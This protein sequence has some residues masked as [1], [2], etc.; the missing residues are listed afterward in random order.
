MTVLGRKTSLGKT[1]FEHVAR[2]L[3][4]AGISPLV[5]DCGA[6]NGMV[7]LPPAYTEI[8]TMVGFEPNPEEY[9]KLTQGETDLQAW[10]RKHSGDSIP[11][12]SKER[13]F[14]CAV[15]DQAGTQTL[16]V[17]Q[18]PGACTLMGPTLPHM[19]NTYY[20]YPWGDPRR[21]SSLYDVHFRVLKECEVSC[22][23]LDDLFDETEIIDFLKVDV[24]GGEI[25][26]FKGAQNLLDRGQ[27]LFIQSE[28]QAFPYYLEHSVF[29]DQH[30]FLTKNGMRL[31]HLQF[32]HMRYQRGSVDIPDAC[33]RSP[34]FAGDAL[35]MIDPDTN[36]LSP[37]IR[38]RLALILLVFGFNSLAL[39]LLCEAALLEKDELAAIRTA[40]VKRPDQTRKRQILNAW[41]NIP[42]AAYKIFS[43]VASK[44]RSS[45]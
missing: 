44:F 7:I 25:R 26:V 36:D 5:V 3:K 19:N 38:Q 27:V 8:S 22:R 13:Y 32:D 33:T 29:G 14:D 11:K 42:L 18:G 16:Y 23:P 30:S 43:S 17:T 20:L 9:Y 10:R 34:L 1:I 39:S 28:F 40:I 35:F 4:D 41:N 21:Q 24:E 37:L 31:I 2:P 45:R 12:F 15:W 6:R